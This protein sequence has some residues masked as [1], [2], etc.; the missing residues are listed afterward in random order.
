MGLVE[1]IIKL[2]FQEFHKIMF[3]KKKTELLNN[4]LKFAK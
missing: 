3:K 2:H 1:F 4:Y